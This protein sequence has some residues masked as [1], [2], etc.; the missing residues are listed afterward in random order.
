MIEKLP[1]IFVCAGNPHG[2]TPAQIGS[3]TVR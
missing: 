3:L 1:G 2:E